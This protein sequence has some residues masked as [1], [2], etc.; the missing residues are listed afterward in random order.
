[1]FLLFLFGT[2]SQYTSYIGHTCRWVRRNRIPTVPAPAPTVSPRACPPQNFS[3]FPR[4]SASASPPQVPGPNSVRRL[5]HTVPFVN[6]DSED[7]P[8]SHH[9]PRRTFRHVRGNVDD[10]PG[11]G[12]GRPVR[13]STLPVTPKRAI[14]SGRSTTSSPPVPSGLL[15]SLWGPVPCLHYDHSPLPQ[16]RPCLLRPTCSHPPNFVTLHFRCPT[17]SPHPA[18]PSS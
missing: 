9:S 11:S 10:S 6:D 3:S 13:T 7:L 14:Q 15:P 5:R 1:M 17:L 2:G 8:L 18:P 4:Q 16:R 12:V